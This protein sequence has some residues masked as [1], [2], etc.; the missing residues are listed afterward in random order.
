[1]PDVLHLT[2]DRKVAPRGQRQPGGV[3]PGR[4]LATIT[5]SF[6]LPSG[7][8]CP[9]KTDWCE[10]ICY[11]ELSENSAGV[12]GAMMHNA[13][14]LS[15]AGTVDGMAALLSEM[16]R[17]YWKQAARLPAEDRLFRIHWDG[18]FFSVDYA[19]AWAKVIR[20]CPQVQFWAYTRSFRPPV[21]VVPVLAGIPNLA[22][23]LS[24]DEYNVE[25][26]IVQRATYDVHLALCADDYRTGR[27]L[28]DLIDQ[29]PKPAI[30][31]P[32]N[33]G[34]MP[35]MTDGRGACVECRVCVDGRRDVLFST[36]HRENV[37]EAPVALTQRRPSNLPAAYGPPMPGHCELIECSAK[38][39]LHSGRG[40]PKKYC[41]EQCR[42]KASRLRAST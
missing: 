22:L 12:R 2:R 30:V 24:V 9:G 28:A 18:D 38:L 40:R 21:D 42:W 23:Y 16:L 14:L 7:L 31:C 13:R 6:G 25:D 4:W 26:A 17:R 36:S 5:N 41:D 27:W 3:R 10:G 37:N 35:L 19:T 11:A 29:P 32:E 1:M 39:P 8:S 33:V 34:R 15:E 20:A